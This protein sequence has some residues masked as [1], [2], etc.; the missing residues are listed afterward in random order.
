VLVCISLSSTAPLRSLNNKRTN[1]KL[2]KRDDDDLNRSSAR[3]V[4]KTRRCDHNNNRFLEVAS[5]RKM[6]IRPKCLMTIDENSVTSDP[7]ATESIDL[8]EKL[9]FENWLRHQSSPRS[10]FSPID[11]RA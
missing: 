9:S 4:L 11:E 8:T 3:A 6:T 7:D 1:M 2:R 5:D 10:R